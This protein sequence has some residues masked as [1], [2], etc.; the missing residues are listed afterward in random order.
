MK[1]GNFEV[2]D[3][4]VKEEAGKRNLVFD[5]RN[6]VYG[7][8]MA[9]DFHCRYHA[10]ALLSEIEADLVICAEVYERVYDEAQ[11]K[12]LSETA[13]LRQKFNVESIWSYRHLG[14]AEK[15]CEQFF[16]MR[17]DTMVKITH[18]LI[19]FDPLLSYLT[20]LR[21]IKAEKTKLAEAGPAYGKCT[22]PFLAT[23]EY[24][25]KSF[26]ETTIVQKSLDILTRLKDVPD[27][28]VLYKNL[29][30]A[31]VKPSFIGSRLLFKETEQLELLDEYS[32][33]KSSVQIFK[34][35]DKAEPLYIVNPPEYSLPPNQ[36]FVMSKTKEIVAGYQPGKISLSSLSKSRKYFERIYESTI[37]DVARANR[38]ELTNE[39]TAELAEIVARY[40]VGYGILE[41]LL[42]DRNLT[43]IYLDSPIGQRPLY[44]VHS[45]FGQCQTN[46][47]YTNEEAEGL[48]S[49]LRAMSGRPFDEA[50]P[51]LD[52]DLP[53]L[54]IRTAIIGPPLAPDGVAFAFRIHKDTPWTLPQFLDKGFL[55]PLAAGLLSFFIDSQATTLITGSRGSGKTSLLTASMLEIMQNNRI[56]VQEDSVTGDSEILVQRN[57][58]MEFTT[59]GSLI[60]GLAEKYGFIE[61]NGIQLLDCNP[62]NIF[63]FS[64]DKKGK[65]AL[66]R[67]SQFSRHLVSKDIIEV[68][69]KSGRKIK[70]TCDHSLF[71]LNS[72]G[73]IIPIRTADLCIGKKIAVPR[74]FPSCSTGLEKFSAFEILLKENRGFFVSEALKSLIA[75]N[76][77]FVK[78]IAFKKGY[79]KAAFSAWK[80][81]GLLP[82]EIFK[83]LS[84][85]S[86]GKF[87]D[88]KF[89]VDKRSKPIP[90]EFSITNDLLL[91]S[92]LWLADGC[93]DG[94]FG[95]VVSVGDEPSKSVLR[96][97]CNQFGLAARLHSDNFSTIISNTNFVWFL[98]NVLNLNGNAYTKRFPGWVF[99]LSQ[100][101]KGVFLKGLFSGDGYATKKEI[102]ISLASKNMVAQIQ[103]VLL[104]MG[105]FARTSGLNPRD[106][107]YKTYIGHAKNFC[108]FRE[109]IG[110]LQEKKVQRLGS[111]CTH[112]PSQD[113]SDVIPLAKETKEKI[114]GFIPGFNRH[115]YISRDYSIGRAK[116]QSMLSHTAQRTCLIQELEKIAY[117]DVFWD[118]IVS[119][120]KMESEKNWVYDFSVPETENFVCQN[121]L[122][123]N[124][125]EI[126]VPYLKEIGF[127]IQRLKTRS[128]IS[129]SKTESEVA[130]AEA[131]RTALRLGD[132][133]LVIGEVRSREAK[134]LYEAMRVGAAGNIV[135]GTIHG[136]SA[137][138][139]WDRVVND[140]GVPT[141]SFK[142]TDVVVVAR[143]IRFSGSLKREKRVVQ[144]TEVKKHWV[145]DPEREGGLLDLML[146]DA[147]KDNLELLEDNLKESELFSKIS[148]TSGLTMKEMWEDIKMRGYSKSFLVELKRNHNVPKLLEAEN[149][150]ACNNKLM[151]FKQEEIEQNGKIDYGQVLGKWK[152]WVQNTYLPRL[153]KKKPETGKALPKKPQGE[154]K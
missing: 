22:Q 20:L 142:A 52:F 59:V 34:H 132:S 14:A 55:N 81:K 31:E 41:V 51:V 145:D 100:E 46:I 62:E 86:E 64:L 150:V 118:E 4:V 135:I 32:V 133:A 13:N 88:L 40:T 113:A 89:K 152:Y 141:T 82:I 138:S 104:E 120:Q 143:P 35:P 134:V 67:V 39:E 68:G 85:T 42:S 108:V 127:S 119:L 112:K 147:K 57:G 47:L 5:C 21:E 53:D 38:V 63:V 151:L 58:Q 109:K 11:A 128:P 18:D 105:I 69:T 77:A 110:F 29:F 9:D 74:Q 136:D 83:E 71:S 65:M 33:L 70:V 92:G 131:L 123:H 87:P 23:L 95:V 10:I 66:K 124:T 50:H 15:E 76:W 91:F 137:Y 117:A 122:A 144:I 28:S 96:N 153:V 27:T 139:V 116:L 149:T 16:S 103:T 17:H 80:R 114:A 130:P 72:E 2:G 106:K 115:D 60:N 111:L 56:L 61:S 26:E 3:Y 24:V 1:I 19:A 94:K 84:G 98:K 54:E 45:E 79:K 73:R 148:R 37:K 12:M 129:V 30:E 125:L 90:V 8:S 25:R 78:K 99:N 107:T 146:F 36:Y 6:C 126:P 49:K 140:L 101:Q 154:K 93:F 75:N 7:A 43:D 44:V 97:V 102:G 121:I 48:V